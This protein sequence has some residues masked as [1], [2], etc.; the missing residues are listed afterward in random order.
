V[1]A[2]EIKRCSVL[3]QFNF[4]CAGTIRNIFAADAERQTYR[5]TT[6]V[7][8]RKLTENRNAFGESNEMDANAWTVDDS[9]YQN[10]GLTLS[11]QGRRGVVTGG[12]RRLSQCTFPNS[13]LLRQEMLHL[14]VT[15]RLLVNKRC[16]FSGWSGRFGLLH[17]CSCGLDSLNEHAPPITG[18]LSQ[19]PHPA[20]L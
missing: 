6:A 16:V 3:C 8:Y 17:I 14:Y 15:L 5:Q 9:V 1:R 4:N 20:H 2:A 10:S 19:P 11:G 7:Y 18:G 12:L 13:T